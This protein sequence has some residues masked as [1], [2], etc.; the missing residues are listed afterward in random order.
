LNLDGKSESLGASWY[1]AE[2]PYRI[3]HMKVV[4]RV[5]GI[6]LFSTVLQ[7]CDRAPQVVGKMKASLDPIV[8]EWREI[9]STDTSS[10]EVIVFMPDRTPESR[11]T[12]R[13]PQTPELVRKMATA[14][15]SLP[16]S[17]ARGDSVIVISIDNEELWK[18]GKEMF[19]NEIQSIDSSSKT[20]TT[21]I[22]FRYKLNGDILE[23]TKEREPD[24]FVEPKTKRYVRAAN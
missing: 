3:N 13:N 7:S 19:K 4:H 11:V 5:T 15:N 12:I 6:L 21:D 20:G 23:L 1:E 24:D 18:R 14:L 17:F 10:I 16:S 8:G 2:N 9:V 22:V